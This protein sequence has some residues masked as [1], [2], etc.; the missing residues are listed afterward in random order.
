VDTEVV[1]RPVETTPTIAGTAFT[2]S[3]VKRGASCDVSE[4]V[5]SLQ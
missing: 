5:A 3:P 4:T 2:E 1:D